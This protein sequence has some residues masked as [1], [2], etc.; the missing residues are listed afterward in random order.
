MM[1][2]ARQITVVKT[3]AGQPLYL[4]VRDSVRA[5][6][7]SGMYGPGERLPSTKDLARQLGV[8]LV[9]AHRAMNELV[10][11]GVLERTQGR[12]TFVHE[13]FAERKLA[14]TRTRIGLICHNSTESDLYY[15]LMTLEGVRQATEQLGA[16][17]LFLAYPDDVRAECTAMVL[18]DPPAEKIAAAVHRLGRRPIISIG[19]HCS[20]GLVSCIEIDNVEMGRRAVQHLCDLGH[21]NLGFMG[22]DDS[23]VSGKQ[24]WA[25]FDSACRQQEVAPRDHNII[26]TSASRLDPRE[27]MALIRALS[28]PKRPTA[29]FAAGYDFSMDVLEAARTVGLVVPRDLSII[30]VDDPPSAPNLNPPLTTFRQ[31]LLELGH[32]AVNTLVERIRNPHEPPQHQTLRAELIIRGSTGVAIG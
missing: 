11:A 24:R 19:T 28:S 20:T 12:G 7:E 23:T 5:A 4:A 29:I 3:R 6:V 14:A 13:R 16:D 18:I 31:P 1:H 27:K 10:E 22:G 32:A 26:R 21:R 30:A 2:T 8:S 25:G 9:T 15:R 17:L